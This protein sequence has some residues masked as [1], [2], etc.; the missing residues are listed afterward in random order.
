MPS[1][2]WFYNYLYDFRTFWNS[3]NCTSVEH[4]NTLDI[5]QMLSQKKFRN[6]QKNSETQKNFIHLLLR[7]KCNFW[8]KETKETKT[9]APRKRV[10][11]HKIWLKSMKEYCYGK[12][13]KINILEDSLLVILLF[14]IFSYLLPLFMNMAF[15]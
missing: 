4:F 9:I 11:F 7:P 1:E 3:S 6:R 10:L 8:T 15:P 5:F 14:Q 12:K 13:S 2:S